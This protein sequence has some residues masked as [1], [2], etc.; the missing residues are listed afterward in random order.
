MD[1]KNDAAEKAREVE[2]LQAKRLAEVDCDGSVS[3]GSSASL[4]SPRSPQQWALGLAASLQEDVRVQ[5]EEWC[6]NVHFEAK[7]S[8]DH[9][10]EVLSQVSPA[11]PQDADPVSPT[12]I[13]T[14]FSV[15]ISSLQ[16]L[17]SRLTSILNCFCQPPCLSPAIRSGRAP[18]AVAHHKE[19]QSSCFKQTQRSQEPRQIGTLCW[20]SLTLG[21][22]AQKGWQRICACVLHL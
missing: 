9:F 20:V 11:T 15:L 21:T 17:P 14:S 8:M 10:S 19:H 6:S 16:L 3:H 22:A 12:P 5:F 4:S 2:M 18:R 13:T 7:A 1:S